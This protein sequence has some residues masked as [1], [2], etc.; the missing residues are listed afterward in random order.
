[1]KRKKRI[2]IG[3]AAKIIG[4]HPDTLRRWER[5]GK[6]K[7]LRTK[8]G[9]RYYTP[10]MLARWVSDEPQVYFNDCQKCG[11]RTNGRFVHKGQE[12]CF[13]CFMQATDD[14]KPF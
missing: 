1:M 13:A 7:P 12:L 8:G 2:R 5:A 6:I 14:D 9:Q 3:Q 11:R 4:V 10:D